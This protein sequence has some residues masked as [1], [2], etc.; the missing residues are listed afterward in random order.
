MN[1]PDMMEAVPLIGRLCANLLTIVSGKGD[2]AFDAR[3]AIG[4]VIATAPTLCWTNTIG[5]ALDNC[6]DLV[7]QSGCTLW[8]MEGVRSE[9]EAEPT[10]LTLGATLTRDYSIQLALAHMAKIIGVMT[11]KSRQDVDDIIAAIQQ[12]FAD[13]EETAADTMDPMV[14]RGLIE[15]RAA[16][17]NHL[18][19]TARPLPS[20][21][22]YQFAKVFPSL[23][24]SQRLYGDASRYDEIRDENK[25]VHPAFC[26]IY[27][28]AL[29]A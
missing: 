5:P 26:P 3:R 25:I 12:P 10:P 4:Q 15:L 28:V 17:V 23:V 1:K 27:G 13:A 8:Q 24:I 7:R 11:F 18:V 21:L 20:L 16:I 2:P 6:F 14:Y 9:L 29:S 22:N 19:Q